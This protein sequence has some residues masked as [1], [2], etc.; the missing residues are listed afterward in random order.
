[1]FG[2]KTPFNARIMFRALLILFLT[3]L[4][5]SCARNPMAENPVAQNWDANIQFP[6]LQHSPLHPDDFEAISINADLHSDI[7]LSKVELYVYEYELYKNENGHPSKRK[8]AFG[9]WGLMHSW[10]FPSLQEDVNLAYEISTGFGPSSTISYE[11]VAY[12]GLGEANTQTVMFD[13][14][15]SE[16]EK[17]KILL[18]KK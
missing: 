17:D 6:L 15:S 14:G 10:N 4:I 12:D 16:F 8:K 2:A 5:F 13:A 1:M 11:I 18:Y 3:T 9:Q 7:G